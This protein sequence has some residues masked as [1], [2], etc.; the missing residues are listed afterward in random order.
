MHKAIKWQRYRHP[1]VGGLEIETTPDVI[2]WFD[3]E[4]PDGSEMRW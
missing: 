3:I 1:G 4:D 2:S